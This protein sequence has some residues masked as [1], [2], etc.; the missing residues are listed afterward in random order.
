MFFLFSCICWIAIFLQRTFLLRQL[1]EF[2]NKHNIQWV[3]DNTLHD[4]FDLFR[5]LNQ[6]LVVSLYH[7][8]WQRKNIFRYLFLGQKYNLNEATWTLG[9]CDG[10]FIFSSFEDQIDE[11]I[12]KI[13]VSQDLCITSSHEWRAVSNQ[14]W[15]LISLWPSTLTPGR[16]PLTSSQ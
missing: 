7:S 6:I 1:W 8:S 15:T 10:Q 4:S 5:K 3:I 9:Y 11:S 2:L 12:I 13:L 14:G 16:W